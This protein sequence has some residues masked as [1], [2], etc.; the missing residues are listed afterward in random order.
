MREHRADLGIALDGDGD[1]LICVDDSGALVDGDELLYI[2]AA[3]QQRATGVCGGVVGTLMSNLG[4]EV[5]L[6][7]LGIPFARARVGD[8][9]VLE[10]MEE[11]GWRLGG[12][13]SGHIICRDVTTTGDGIVSAL[14]VLAAI[15]ASGQSLRA[16]RSRVTKFPQTMINVRVA[17][18]TDIGGNATIGD[19]VRA[20][21]RALGDRGRVLLRP[22]GTEP[23]IRVMVEGHDAAQVEQHARELADVVRSAAA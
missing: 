6:R 15:C 5:A 19:A 17:R 10:M 20:V 21:E 4:M 1:R 14:R 9:Y 18:R 16:L 13:S 8:R 2:I 22:S 11:K 12:E 23:V 3:E 7:E